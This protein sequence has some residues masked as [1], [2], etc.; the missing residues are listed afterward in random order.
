MDTSFKCPPGYDYPDEYLHAKIDHPA[1]VHGW[2][3]ET[4]LSE[5]LACDRLEGRRTLNMKSWKAVAGLVNSLRDAENAEA[6]LV[7]PKLIFRSLF[8]TFHCQFPWQ[9]HYWNAAD[10]IRAWSI[11]Q[12]DL[13][14][15][16]FQDRVG[17][18]LQSFIRIGMGWSVIFNGKPFSAPPVAAPAVRIC[19]ED[20]AAFVRATSVSLDDACQAARKIVA[21]APELGYRRSAMRERPLI[22]I[23]EGPNTQFVRP[24]EQLLFWRIT[25]GL[26][27][28]V[29]GDPRAP[30]EIGAQFELY[31]LRLMA[32]FA[33][34]IA[35]QGEIEYGTKQNPRRSTDCIIHVGGR[36]EVLIECKAKKLPLLAQTSLVESAART[37]AVTEIAKGVVQLCRFEQAVLNGSVPGFRYGESPI[38]LLVTLDAWIFTGSDI[39]GEVY[40]VAKEIAVVQGVSTERI[41]KRAVVM[42]TATELDQIASTYRYDDLKRICTKAIETKFQEYALIS[43]ARECF[44]EDRREPKYPLLAE[45]DGLIGL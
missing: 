5:M 1:A 16:I 20:V 21:A 13:L 43:V 29:I 27:Y 44:S 33:I 10:S 23:G 4:L 42:C 19:A 12:S 40:R 26:Y 8:R 17:L 41:D 37:V 2:E 34:G 28:D 25:S 22:S 14:R 6:G 32:A 45:L 39:M 35:V 18:E 36:V 31:I 3:L 30:K 24:I 38:L 9:T 11:F 15:S 7:D